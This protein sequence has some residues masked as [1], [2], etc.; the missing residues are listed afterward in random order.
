[1]FLEIKKP[2]ACGL[3]VLYFKDSRFG[4]IVC[5]ACS[6]VKLFKINWLYV[7]RWTRGL[8]NNA[9]VVCDVSLFL[10]MGWKS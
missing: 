1:V 8:D 6:A 3:F 10:G 5:Q 9:R 2:A 4:E 7:V